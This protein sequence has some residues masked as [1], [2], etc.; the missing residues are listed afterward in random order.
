M[1]PG[2]GWG[3]AWRPARCS[4]GDVWAEK[5]AVRCAPNIRKP[6]KD[7]RYDDLMNAFEYG[8]IG[9]RLSVP[10]DLDVLRAERR[11]AKMAARQD[12]AAARERRGPTMEEA[13]RR[14]RELNRRNRDRD[15]EDPP[16]H[17][18]DGSRVPMGGRGMVVRYSGRV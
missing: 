1:W 5:C 10:T 16:R 17:G 18:R 3:T 7:T 11:L 12:E 9:E 14:I 2:S 8:A 15:P 13:M 4:T 6:K